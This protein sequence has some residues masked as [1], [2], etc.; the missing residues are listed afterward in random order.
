MRSDDDAPSALDG[1][2][3]LFGLLTLDEDNMVYAWKDFEKNGTRGIH[4]QFSDTFSQRASSSPELYRLKKLHA[5]SD[6]FDTIYYCD[7]LLLN[8]IVC[9]ILLI[10]KHNI[11]T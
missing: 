2:L 1:G 11:L 6:P 10:K 9:A 4:R 8:K 7:R 5:R 3:L